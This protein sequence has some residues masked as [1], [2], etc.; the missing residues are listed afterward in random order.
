MDVALAA[1]VGIGRS[2]RAH[3]M[4]PLASSRSALNFSHRSPPRGTTFLAC[5]NCHIPFG[6][7]IMRGP[8]PPSNA[9]HECRPRLMLFHV[10][11]GRRR[12]RRPGL[13]TVGPVSHMHS[14]VRLSRARAA[15]SP[16]YSTRRNPT[17]PS[18]F[19]HPKA[20]LPTS[21]RSQPIPSLIMSSRPRG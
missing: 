21:C 19:S 1:Y 14:M 5:R 17:S 10:R 11:M 12:R 20:N 13:E 7:R 9:R 15:L 2:G 18:S 6:W 16:L 3:S 4:Y 8:S